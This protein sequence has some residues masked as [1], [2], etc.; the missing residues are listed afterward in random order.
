MAKVVILDD[1]QETVALLAPPLTG[2]GHEV[3]TDVAP[4][5]F[6]RIMRFKPDV[7]T[8]NLYR[9]QDAFDR[10]IRN[11]EQDVIGFIPL[12]EMEKYPAISVIPIILVGSCLQEKDVPTSVNYDLFISFPSEVKIYF[13]KVVEIA[14]TV[15]TRRRIS[16][17]VCPQCGSR[18]TYTQKRADDLFCP[19]C[20]AAVAIVDDQT[21]IARSGDGNFIP[22][23]MATLQPPQALPGKLGD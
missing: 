15:K 18:L 16:E 4:I 7:I 9:H 6:E 10:P 5:D 17:Y 22:C 3:L 23:D 1:L 11:V 13:P 19:R 21:C 14:A 12:V 20:H 8:L 2:Q